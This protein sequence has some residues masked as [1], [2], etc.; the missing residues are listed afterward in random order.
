MSTRRLIRKSWIKRVLTILEAGYPNATT[1]LNFTNPFELVVAV[2]LSAQTTDVR[3]N[4]VTPALFERFPTAFELAEVEPSEVEPYIATVGLYRNKAKHLVGM[5]KMLV[6]HHNGEV[7]RTREALEAL[8]GVGRKTA[9]VVLSNAMD[10]PAIAVDT[11]VYRVSRRI[12]LAQVDAKNVR[13]VED[14]L[15]ESIPKKLWSIAHH[16]LILHGRRVCKSRKPL[17][18]DCDVGAYCLYYRTERGMSTPPWK[19][20]AERESA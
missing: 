4:I 8:P 5:A 6:E 14:H 18:D 1:E 10:I 3:V 13:V 16:W 9:N 19:G 12:G 7:P 2:A 11:H 17:C 15:M 20:L